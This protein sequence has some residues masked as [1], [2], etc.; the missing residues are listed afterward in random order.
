MHARTRRQKEVFDFIARYIDKH[1]HKPSY[2]L[3]G[4]ELGIS[5]KAGVHKHIKA[6]EEQGLLERRRV[7]GTFDIVI[8]R[9]SN[10]NGGFFEIAWLD[11]P[12]NGA[13]LEDWEKMPVII[14][15][16]M[17]GERDPDRYYAYRVRDNSLFDKNILEDDVVLVE[18]RSLVRD[19]ECTVVVVDKDK[20][21]LRRYYRHGAKVELHSANVD[22]DPIE[23]PAEKV[24]V[25]GVCRGL[26]RRAG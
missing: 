5:A 3:I 6:L 26:L 22:F 24:E 16:F 10:G 4:R 14:P 21:V 25:K 12:L 2:Q 20:T 17:L 8:H 7:N 13:R 19:G 18:K 15:A 23:R 9:P 1:G 11:V